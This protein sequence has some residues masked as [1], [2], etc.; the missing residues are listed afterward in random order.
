MSSAPS[1]RSEGVVGK[2]DI[3]A[4]RRLGRWIRAVWKGPP[5]FSLDEPQRDELL[6]RVNEAKRLELRSRR[7]AQAE[8]SGDYT[9]A[10]LGHGLSFSELRDYQPGD[11]PRNIQW[12]VTARFGKPYVKVFHEERQLRVMLVIDVSPSVLLTHRFTALQEFAALL[13]GVCER[14]RDRV[15]LSLFGM[16][17][18]SASSALYI[19]PSQS[20]PHYRRLLLRL[21]ELR[22]EFTPQPPF[23][24]SE[25]RLSLGA[26]A[27]SLVKELPKHCLVFLLSDFE[28]EID[29]NSVSV[30]AKAHDVTGISLLSAGREEKTLPSG[31]LSV[32]EPEN[33]QHSFLRASATARIR[34][35]EEHEK[36]MWRERREAL[37]RE[38]V[39]GFS[40]DTSALLTL[41]QVIAQRMK[42]RR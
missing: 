25:T 39:R 21:S 5:A 32:R 37:A 29:P 30:L 38:G 6:S 15:G 26:H 7:L 11:D 2:H 24:A 42:E 8:L 41:R 33:F 22:R 19:P 13:I 36:R 4:P 16:D 23:Q 34:Q 20:R 28:E 3:S 17:D 31:L 14:N 18:A 9:S 1:P 27:H 12:N 40:Y 35:V 10:F